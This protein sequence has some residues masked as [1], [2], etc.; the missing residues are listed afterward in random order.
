MTYFYILNDLGIEGVIVGVGWDFWGAVLE[1]IFLPE[2]GERERMTLAFV[3][4]EFLHVKQTLKP[5]QG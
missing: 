4:W 5:N 1:Q 3:H 2:E